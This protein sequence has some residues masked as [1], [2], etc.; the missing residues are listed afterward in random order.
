MSALPITRLNFGRSSSVSSLGVHSLGRFECFGEAALEGPP[1][2][3]TEL[4]RVGQ[5]ANGIYSVVSDN[6]ILSVYCDFSKLPGEEGD[7][8]LSNSIC[9]CELMFNVAQV[10][11]C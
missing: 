9:E 5:S 11:N 1:S 4:W 3:C 2:S 10:R 8:F 7:F 6:S